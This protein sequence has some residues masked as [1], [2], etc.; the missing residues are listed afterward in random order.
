MLYDCFLFN[1]EFD[2]LD[3][4]FQE[5]YD[6]VDR[7][8]LVEGHESFQRQ[9]KPFHFLNSAERYQPYAD[10]IIRVELKEPISVHP[11]QFDC[12]RDYEI[13]QRNAIL[14]G[15]EGAEAEDVILISDADEIP[16]RETVKF[17][18]GGLAGK[19]RLHL[20]FHYYSLNC[21]MDWPWHLSVA[22]PYRML[23]ATTP[24]KTRHLIEAGE[25]DHQN[26]GWHFSFFGSNEDIRRK[27]SVHSEVWLADPKFMTE[28]NL[29]RAR[30]G[31]VDFAA[32][33]IVKMHFCPEVKFL[34]ET[35][36]HNLKKYQELGWFHQPR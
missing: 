10:K 7:F 3:L 19:T 2:I 12:I 4:R 5:L 29:N 8:V 16:S 24:Q 18:A 26:S 33:E 28:E 21:M 36:K 34:P 9:P 27:M 15:L 1:D 13:A 35:I 23:Q 11:P 22:L 31:S 17:L 20:Q 14:R 6:Y 25:L 30:N 32:R